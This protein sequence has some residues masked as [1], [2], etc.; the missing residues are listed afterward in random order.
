VILPLP[1]P[2]PSIPFAGLALHF[3]F[4]NVVV[5]H[6]GFSEFWFGWR[7]ARIFPAAEELKTFVET[8]SPRPDLIRTGRAEAVRYW[9]TG[10]LTGGE[11]PPAV[12]LSMTDI[13]SETTLP[14]P[15]ITVDTDQHLLGL[16]EQFLRWLDSCGLP[17]PDAQ[18]EKALWPEKAT[19]AGLNAVGRALETFYVQSAYGGKAPV[20][21]APFYRAVETAPSAFMSHDLLGWAL[22]RNQDYPASQSA[23]L[24]SVQ[25][26][27]HGA[28]AM[29]GLMWCA[30]MTGDRKAALDWAQRKA[31]SCATDVGA[32]REKALRLLNKYKGG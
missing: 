7:V 6:P 12:T 31:E 4:G 5:L 11:D 18:R 21:A 1:A 24:R 15:A 19:P 8:G 13:E 27:A 14:A 23:F 32:A 17:M 20:D 9:I 16:R 3:L 25:I 10:S 2:D 26:N 22:Y 28:G 29:A 30:V